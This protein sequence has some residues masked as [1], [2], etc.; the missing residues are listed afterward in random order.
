MPSFSA[1]NIPLGTMAKNSVIPGKM[2]GVYKVFVVIN[3]SLQ[4]LLGDERKE[5]Y[6]GA[7]HYDTG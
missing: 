3:Q 4:P 6:I 7:L 5:R 1:L 2:D